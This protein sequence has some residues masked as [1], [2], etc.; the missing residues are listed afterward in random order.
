MTLIACDPAEE[1]ALTLLIQQSAELAGQ[2]AD[3][4]KAVISTTK[5]L[6]AFSVLTRCMAPEARDQLCQML[7]NDAAIR[8]ARAAADA[9]EAS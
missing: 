6:H 5:P 7:I 9:R 3:G 8:A 4:T 1:D 2:F